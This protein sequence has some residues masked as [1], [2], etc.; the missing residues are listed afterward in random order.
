MEAR[1]AALATGEEL[2]ALKVSFKLAMDYIV[3]ITKPAAT[4][5]TLIPLDRIP[6][7]N[8]ALHCFIFVQSWR[9]IHHRDSG[10]TSGCAFCF[11]QWLLSQV[12]AIWALG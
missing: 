5:L 9:T 10:G 8:T 12:R 7:A 2:A 6:I 4:T 3:L 11:I 1:A